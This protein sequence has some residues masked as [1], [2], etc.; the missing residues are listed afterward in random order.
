MVAAGGGSL[1]WWYMHGPWRNAGDSLLEHDAVHFGPV[2]TCLSLVRNDNVVV[3]RCRSAASARRIQEHVDQFAAKREIHSVP[4]SPATHGPARSPSLPH[5]DADF[6]LTLVNHPSQYVY[7]EP[8]YFGVSHGMA[9]VLM[10][11]QRDN[12]WLAQSP[13]GGGQ[14]N[15]AWDFQWFVQDFQIGQAYGFVMRAA[16]LPYESREQIERDTRI[17]RELLNR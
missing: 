4:R 13:S 5:V 9:Y 2:P 10:F 16:Y 8:W 12:I 17:H 11:R 15:P 6:P 14:G 1:Y 7:T 3:N